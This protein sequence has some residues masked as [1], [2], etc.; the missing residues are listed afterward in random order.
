M[1]CK[2]DDSAQIFR[3]PPMDAH[4]KH[5][6]D[7]ALRVYAYREPLGKVV[8]V[9]VPFA[10]DGTTHWTFD[11]AT[12]AVNVP[13]LRVTLL[14]GTLLDACLKPMPKPGDV[15]EFDRLNELETKCKDALPSGMT[16]VYYIHR[17][18]SY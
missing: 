1:N 8:T 6:L 12:L 5:C 14:V 7:C 3:A 16:A 15:D 4:A 17:N 9:R 10:E 18:R 13:E 11:E 2:P